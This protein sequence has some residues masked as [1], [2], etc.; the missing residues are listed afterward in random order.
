MVL[1]SILTLLTPSYQR[2][3]TLNGYFFF[4]VFAGVAYYSA[5][6]IL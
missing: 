2:H 4:S 5:A 6:T 3:Y 1:K